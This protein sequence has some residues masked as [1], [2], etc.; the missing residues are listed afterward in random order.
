MIFSLFAEPH[1]IV[2]WV[3]A[4]WL[5]SPAVETGPVSTASKSLP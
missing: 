1:K 2:G 5:Y 3:N 4:L